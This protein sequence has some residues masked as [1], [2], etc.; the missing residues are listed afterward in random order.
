MATDLVPSIPTFRSPF[1]PEEFLGIKLRTAQVRN[2]VQHPGNPAPKCIANQ[3][4]TCITTDPTPTSLVPTRTDASPV[5]VPHNRAPPHTGVRVHRTPPHRPRRS[6]EGRRVRRRQKGSKQGCGTGP[7]CSHDL[8][9]R[10]TRDASRA[11]VARPRTAAA[12]RPGP[13]AAVRVCI[14]LVNERLGSVAKWPQGDCG[15]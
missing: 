12:P 5:F 11:R 1:D 14:G 2:D 8:V 15:Y 13:A 3:P 9:T 7:G 6:A 4:Q 10:G